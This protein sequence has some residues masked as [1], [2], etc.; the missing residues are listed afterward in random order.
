MGYK[1]RIPRWGP[2]S[3]TL[4][5]ATIFLATAI[6]F[7]S[8]TVSADHDSMTVTC[9]DSI[10]EGNTGQMRV[11]KPGYQDIAVSVFTYNGDFTASASD[12][13]EYHGSRIE[14]EGEASSIWIPVVTTEDTLPE[15]DETFSIGFWDDGVWHGCVATIEDDDA[16]AITVVE[17]A[18]SPVDHYAYRAGD[19]ID[20]AVNLDTK[21][22]VQGTPLLSLYIGDQGETEWRGARYH[23][24]SGTRS[25]VFRYR[26]QP[27]DLD[28][29]G[30]TVSAA[31]S[32]EDG[33][34]AYGFS[35]NIYARG[36]DVP[37]DYAHPAVQGGADQ[38][39][40]GRPYVQNTRV[41]SSPEEGWNAYRV[42]QTIEISL[43]F[44]TDVV[45]EGQVS[46]GLSLGLENY[47]WDEAS[48][49]AWYLRGSGTD[50]LVFGYTVVPGDTD[51]KGVMIATGKLVGN[52]L[53]RFSGS[54]VIKAKGTDVEA[55][56]LLPGTGRLRE[57]K[58]DT[59][60]PAISDVSITSQ[61]A[62]GEA[63]CADEMVGVEVTFSEGVM[64]SGDVRLELD[65][66]GV[67]RDA[68]L[69]AEQQNAFSDTLM[70]RYR[71][72]ES[73]Q[74]T[75]G[76]GIDANAVKL[77]GG[78]IHDAA[79]NSVALSHDAVVADP[80]HMVTAATAD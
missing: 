58:V 37:I 69:L 79:G 73:D 66:G 48:R 25:L 3:A 20:V 57:H 24:G 5:I 51:P 6:L 78:G 19:M 15:H 61:P 53:S 62:N 18:S 67:S 52:P 60:P 30:I 42:N 9:P 23:S 31:A 38:L 39:V 70:F 49:E 34:P 75:D 22:E 41:S 13:T 71:V 47:N 45:V 27:Q 43:S 4:M 11:R 28:L 10:R 54:G 46:V 77:N 76:I 21:A 64:T 55:H 17:I 63:Y 32:N 56:S 1:S 33:I 74:D 12:F 26:V 72:H 7:S 68:T 2:A 16:P 80:T 40:D 44:D 29:D 50:T 65:V 35:G 59:T 14:S 36:T 8:S